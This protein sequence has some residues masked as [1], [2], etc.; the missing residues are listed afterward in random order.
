MKQYFSVQQTKVSKVQLTAKPHFGDKINEVVKQES[1]EEMEEKPGV[2]V[3]AYNPSY[4]GA[5]AEE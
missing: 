3:D 5:E 2:V 4:S 1:S